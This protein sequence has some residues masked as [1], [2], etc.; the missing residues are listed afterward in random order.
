MKVSPKKI[1]Q[2][3]CL[4][5]REMKPKREMTRIV[6]TVDGKIEIDPTGKKSGR[7][8]YICKE[9]KCLETALNEDSLSRALAFKVTKEMV[10]YLRE[11]LSKI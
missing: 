5:C 4:G 3:M 7:G 9:P 11:D 1:P 2:R 6:R 8:T 10:N